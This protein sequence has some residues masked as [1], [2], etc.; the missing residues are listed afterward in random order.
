MCEETYSIKQA[1]HRH[2]HTAHGWLVA[3][4]LCCVFKKKNNQERAW[5]AERHRENK[6]DREREG[7]H[8]AQRD[9]T[10]GFWV[11][12]G[13]S[14]RTPQRKTLHLPFLCLNHSNSFVLSF[15]LF[16]CV[17][18]GDSQGQ[19]HTWDRHTVET[20]RKIQEKDDNENFV[21]IYSPSPMSFLRRKKQTVPALF[22]KMKVKGDRHFQAPKKTKTH[23]KNII[24]LVYC[25]WF[26]F[27]LNLS[28]YSP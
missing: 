14:T 6:K 22:H 13:E 17:S 2:T 1:S 7:E 27:G 8:D 11:P 19:T 26:V 10:D 25:L 20:L 21:M 23:H 12:H 4:G 9:K 24:K 28:H 3:K 16:F 5:K 18:V 15:I